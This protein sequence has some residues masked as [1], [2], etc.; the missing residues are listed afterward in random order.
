MELAFD[1][2]P[3]PVVEHPPEIQPD[4]SSYDAIVVAASGGKDSVS[5]LLACIENGAPLER[6]ELWHHDVDGREG[7]ALFD[8]PVTRSYVSALAKAFDLPLYFSWKQGGLEREMLREN[9]RTAPISFQTPEGEIRSVGGVSGK[10]GTRL[11]FPQVSADLTTRFCS[12][13]AKIDVSSAA[14]CNQ[15][16]FLGKKTLFVTGERAQESSARARYKTF[17]PHRTDRRDGTRRNRHVDHWRPIHGWDER[18]VWEIIERHRVAPHPAYDAGFGRVSCMNC[19]FASPAQ[20]STILKFAPHKF[21]PIANYE[22]Q[23]GKTIH[24][25]LTVLERAAK[26]TPYEAANEYTM[27]RCLSEHFD[28]PIILEPGQWRLP[29][30]A[31]GENAG[32]T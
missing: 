10:L 21:M 1:P 28:E 32:P 25:T 11:Q 31:F 8:W 18:Q 26:G 15:D 22:K 9:A 20:L 29:A 12:A 19:I 14:I 30:G 5:C 7:S 13:Y 17:E 24:R 3:I 16:R 2:A 27:G 4:L 23:F 6:I